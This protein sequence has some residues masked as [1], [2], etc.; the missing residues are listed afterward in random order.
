MRP[1]AEFP[2]IEVD[3]AD[4]LDDLLADEECSTGVGLP[5]EWKPTDPPYVGCAWDST[6]A[7]AQVL[8]FATVRITVWAS[9]TGEAKRLARLTHGLLLE[10]PEARPLAGPFPAR[11]PQTRAEIAS[12]TIRWSARSV[13]IPPA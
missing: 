8:A 12:F 3:V 1:R 5:D 13:P 10:R 11:D 2:D 4:V 6:E 9:S 7:I